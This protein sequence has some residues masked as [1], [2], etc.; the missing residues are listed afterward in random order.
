MP[1]GRLKTAQDAEDFVR[2]CT[3][4]GTGGGGFPESGLSALVG[5]LDAGVPVGWVDP[6]EI[7]D[8]ALVASVFLSGSSAPPTPQ[9]KSE[10]DRLG[11]EE[12][13]FDEKDMLAQALEELGEHLR[14]PV[15]ALVPPEIGAANAPGPLAVGARAKLYV[16]DGDYA[17]RS[18]PEVRGTTFCM[19]KRKPWPLACVDRFGNVALIKRAAN[20]ETLEKLA[21]LPVDATFGL[22]GQAAFVLSGKDMKETVI[23]GTLTLSFALGRFIRESRVRSRDVVRMVAAYVEGWL[24][25]EGRISRKEERKSGGFVNGVVEIADGRKTLTLRYRNETH[26]A[27]LDGK[28][29]A[30]SPDIVSVLRADSGEPTV[31]AQLRAGDEV[32][33]VAAKARLQLRTPAGISALGPRRWGFDFDYVPVEELVKR[34]LTGGRL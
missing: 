2:G 17:G 28:A 19:A 9:E 30:M 26:L 18:V 13:L 20:A 8:D 11:L 27:S 33:V 14:K 34:A 16:V 23:P 3:F 5:E 7:P 1:S 15:F 32:A 24:L 12:T 25:I 4:F 22:A 31:H 10:L 21:R 6:S 29:V